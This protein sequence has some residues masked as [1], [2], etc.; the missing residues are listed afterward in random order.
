[1][2]RSRRGSS[3][4]VV[5]RYSPALRGLLYLL[6]SDSSLEPPAHRG[7]VPGAFQCARLARASEERPGEGLWPPGGVVVV[8]HSSGAGPCSR[9]Q[10]DRGGLF[11][12]ALRAGI[13]LR[14]TSHLSVLGP[15]SAPPGGPGPFHGWRRCGPAEPP[16]VRRP[17]NPPVPPHPMRV[18]NRAGMTLQPEDVTSRTP[19]GAG[20]PQE[21]IRFRRSWRSR[22]G[23]F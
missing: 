14:C 6:S 4:R 13:D 9:P 15:G 16:L 11:P 3:Y 7:C 18:G 1:M 23:G 8:G 10:R 2:G 12:L 22:R 17:A 19:R 21:T 20:P 5:D